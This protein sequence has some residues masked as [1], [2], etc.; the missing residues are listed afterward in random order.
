MVNAHTELLQAAERQ[1]SDSSALD[2]LY[3]TV[4]KC[5]VYEDLLS[6]MSVEKSTR[7]DVSSS[8]QRLVRQALTEE[9]DMGFIHYFAVTKGLASYVRLSKSIDPSLRTPLLSAASRYSKHPLFL[10]GL[11]EYCTIIPGELDEETTRQLLQSFTQNLASPSHE[12]RSLSL[13]ILQL[14]YKQSHGSESVSLA[15]S[16]LIEDT[17]LSMSAS[18]SLSMHVRRLAASYKGSASDPWLV[19]TVPYFCF[20]LLTV[21]FA[22]LWEDAVEAL[23]VIGEVAA[24]DKIISELAFDWLSQSPEDIGGSQKYDPQ[25]S[26]ESNLTPFECSNLRELE[27]LSLDSKNSSEIAP[28][29][30]SK[31]T[32]T[33]MP[34]VSSYSPMARS[35]ALKVLGHVP[36]IAEKHSRDL[37]PMFLGWATRVSKDV[38]DDGSSEEELSVLAKWPRKDQRAMTLLFAQ[39]INPRALFK[40]TQVHEALIDLLA[41]GDVSIQTAALKALFTWKSPSIRPYE[42]HLLNLLDDARFRDEIAVFVHVSEDE[43]RIQDDHRKELLPVLLRLLFGRCLSRKGAAGGKRGMEA[44]RM[45]V[46]SA[47]GGF[48]PDEL[49]EFI[50]V[51]LRELQGVQVIVDGEF[52]EAAIDDQKVTI[53][54]QVAIINMME[55]M[56]K[57]LGTKVLPFVAD[58]LNALLYCLVPACRQ[59]SDISLDDTVTQVSSLRSIRQIGM[60]CIN[61][62]FA[63][64]ATFNWEVYMPII[65]QELINPRLEKLPIETA[66][67]V[68]GVLQIFS[69]WTASARTILF[70][71]KYNDTVLSKIADCLAVESAKDEVKLFAMGIPKSIIKL[72]GDPETETL[73]IKT[74]IVKDLLQP[75]TDAFLLRIGELLQKFSLQKSPPKELF[76]TG[77]ETVSIIAPYVAGT[78]E[79]RNLLNISIFLLDQPAKTVTPKSKSEILQVLQHFI[80]LCDIHDDKELEGKAFR[81]ISS[82]FGYFKDRNSRETLSHVLTTF[83]QGDQELQEAATLCADLNSFSTKRLDEPDF[84]RRL[85]AF[86]D[87]NEDKWSHFSVKQ[88]RPIIYN[89]LYYIRDND[90]LPIRTSAG[91]SL[92]RFLDSASR[93][94]KSADEKALFEDAALTILLPALRGGA[95]EA[96]EIVRAEYVAV[97]GHLV[98]VFSEWDPVKDMRSLLVEEDDDA[99]FFNNVLHIQQHRRLRA[100]RRLVSEAKKG[101]LHSSNIAHFFIPLI[102]HFVFDQADEGAQP[103]ANE[104]VVTLGVLTE[105]LDWAQYRAL[106]RRF[107]S[108]VKNKPDQVKVVIRLLGKIIDSMGQAAKLK[109]PEVDSSVNMEID[110]T[111]ATV[112]STLTLTMPKD[113]EKL[114][115]DLTSSFLP[116]LTSYLH[117]KDESTVSLRVPVAVSIVKILNL[118]PFAQLQDRLPA[119]LTDIAHILRSKSQEAR[120]MTRKTLA[121]ISTLLG[122]QCFGFILKELRGALLRGYQL[123]VLSYTVH[124]I[125]VATSDIYKPGDLD[126]CLPSIVA[127]I[128]DDIFGTTGQE[129]DAEEYISAMKE[130]KSSKS[131]D[132]MDIVAKIT[133]LDHLGALIRPLRAL[134]MEKLTLKMVTKI[135]ELLRRIG[136]GLL[137]NDSV[138][139]KDLLVFCYEVI[140]EV[141]QDE[142]ATPKGAK[143]QNERA[144][145]YLIQ[146]K[147]QDKNGK[148]GSTSS[149]TYKLA[150]F[151][152]DVLRAVLQKHTVLQTPSNLAGFLPILGDALVQSHQEVQISALRLLTTIIK[153][154]LQAIDNDAPI[155]VAQAVTLIKSSPST[156]SEVA[157]ASLKLISAVLRD[158]RE[159]PIK[160]SYIAYLLKHLKQDL[161]EPDRQGV[162][163]YFIK[164]VMARKVVIPEVYEIADTVATIMVTNHTRTARDLARGV[165]FQF[166]M[167]YP[168]AKERLSKQMEF[169][170]KNLDY[171]HREGRESVMEVVHLLLRKMGDNLVQEVVGM[172][173]VPL[174]MRLI[175]DDSPECREMAGALLKEIFARADEDKLNVFLG[176]LRTWI[177][178][179]EQVL[180]ARVALQ[181]YGIYVEEQSEKAADEIPFIQSQILNVLKANVPSS[182]SEEAGDWELVYFSLQTFSK[183][184]EI[185]TVFS[186]AAEPLWAAVRS[187]T[188]F[189]H[190]W[191]KLSATRLLGLYFA[192]FARAN[193]QAG[194]N[195][196]PLKTTGGL[197]L[198]G[199]DILLLTR[200][201]V[202]MLRVPELSA[203]L[204]SQTAKNLL[205]LGR[206]LDANGLEWMDINTNTQNSLVGQE[207]DSEDSSDEIGPLPSIK[208][209]LDRDQRSG[210]QYLVERLSSIVRREPASFLARKNLLPRT[211]ALQILSALSNSLSA[212]SLTPLLPTILLPLHNLTDSSIAAPS[213]IDQVYLDKYKAMVDN[214]HELL[215]LLQKKV[216]TGVFVQQLQ[217]V[218]EGVRERREGRRSKRRVEAITAPEKTEKE[219]R[220]KVERKKERRKEK[221]GDERSKRRGW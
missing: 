203:E 32:N 9:R 144:Q 151:S 189:P 26:K 201:S 166:L 23:K 211:T 93:V 178:Q 72:I 190:A 6:I 188:T 148:R 126:Y 10:E 142:R 40:S 112:T 122:P 100:L 192:E 59:L 73:G 28:V 134:L 154:P 129:K 56:L 43:S 206:C 44:T 215:S 103:L 15:T 88:W 49:A 179:Y 60:R 159:V 149:Y 29:S 64:C 218:R 58:L 174:V 128:M 139:S 80:P 47:L 5:S 163:F 187:C 199:Q 113:R 220:R 34:Q 114:A 169:L 119:V 152:L 46:L 221:G 175:N 141:Y 3:A 8:L 86:S 121:E 66:Q 30:I 18:R 209:G 89:M 21:K 135:D 101:G 99:S 85:K 197:Q 71:V 120:D 147:S 19:N 68:S 76:E 61:L 20:G 214:A 182:A 27:A 183:I 50:K 108:Y 84:D 162:V 14:L 105:W 17:P 216:G 92:R 194:L 217:K 65:F 186:S 2:G 7:D 195:E 123:H 124:S 153:V 161:E 193:S 83:A 155:Y 110:S 176:L 219:K 12:L 137:R 160:E 191:V 143:V 171:Q 150:R 109:Y 42:E 91:Y 133:T 75:N 145:R 22:S 181:C 204:A 202:A 140:Q 97:F 74:Q 82:L 125:L 136:I 41:S 4:E 200:R 67:S 51:S 77:I 96:S 24:G 131:Y 57:V 177:T 156:N 173:F 48:G 130:V 94:H 210:I 13:R 213:S 106:F 98:K 107:V 39:F 62:L 33:E 116:R 31:H 95:R 11:L 172:F 70:L 54:K 118:L 102:E 78:S 87:I 165:Y 117:E 35:Q 115:V 138:K 16:I 90:E 132:S 69:T 63:K 146:L 168:Q 164:A 212:P 52:N 167:E 25:A 55:D 198:S 104:A 180:L 205:F 208:N 157:Q 79:G 36:R 207:S 53:R 158:R 1:A 38:E 170:V 196:L 45:A 81:T 37:V 111:E 127:I 185:S 184:C